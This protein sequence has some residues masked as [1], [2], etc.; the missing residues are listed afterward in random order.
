MKTMFRLTFILI[1]LYSLL[2]CSN[3]GRSP[4]AI[5]KGRKKNTEP[6]MDPFQHVSLTIQILRFQG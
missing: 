5:D 1:V 4:L 2:S 3:S 6:E